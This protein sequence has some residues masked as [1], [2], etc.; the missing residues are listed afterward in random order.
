[1]WAQVA[2]RISGSSIFPFHHSVLLPAACLTS[3]GLHAPRTACK[4]DDVHP[5]LL[6]DWDWGRW[7]YCL[8][9][10]QKEHST[11]APVASV[12]AAGT[13]QKCGWDIQSFVVSMQFILAFR[14]QLLSQSFH[15]HYPSADQGTALAHVLGYVK[16]T[17][18]LCFVA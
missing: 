5:K 15:M 8:D 6:G 12:C 7:D 4:K 17:K 13:F 18:L 14:A 1:M 2:A 3:A 9:R 10:D 11:A 16:H